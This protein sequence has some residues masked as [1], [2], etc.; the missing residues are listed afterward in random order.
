MPFKHPDEQTRKAARAAAFRR[1][2]AK[3]AEKY[4]A[5]HR[6]SY[7]RNRDTNLVGNRRYKL[8]RDYGVTLE[9]YEAMLASQ[10]GVCAVCKDINPS[11]KRLAVDHHHESGKVRGLL[12][13]RCNTMIGHARE[14]IDILVAAIGYLGVSH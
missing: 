4:R 6:A 2:R 5:L 11:G 7:Q 14:R 10:A 13:S 3:N 12:C 1:Y 8:S 9:S